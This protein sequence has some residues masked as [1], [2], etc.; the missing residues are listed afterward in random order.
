MELL[1]DN[2]S[3]LRRRQPSHTFNLKTTMALGMCILRAIKSV[4]DRGYL[5]RD[6]KPVCS[7]LI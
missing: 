1:G 5:H 7:L 2:L 6:I 4:H 3:V